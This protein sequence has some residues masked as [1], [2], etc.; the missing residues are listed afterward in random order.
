MNEHEEHHE[1]HHDHEHEHD[2]GAEKS[3][4]IKI[5][6]SIIF[7]IIAFIVKDEIAKK[8]LFLISY[9]IVGFKVLKEAVQNIFK[10]EIFD[11][12]F[13]MSVATI[14]ALIISEFPEAVAAMLLYQIGEFFQGVATEKS[15]K[16][17][18]DLMNIKPDTAT[19]LVDGKEVEM[20]PEKVQIGAEI[21]VKPGE[22]IPLDGVVI[23]GDSF[24]DT[25]ALTG[26]SVPRA[27]KVS[28]EVL[29]G[30]INQNGIL[31]IKVTKEFT[32]ST[33]NK[34]LELTQNA[35]EQKSKSE[36]F[37][38]KFAKVYT[39]TVVLIAVVL[40][41]LPPVI[42]KDEFSKWV[43]RALSFLVV[44][45]PCSLVISIPLSFFGGIGGAAKKGI[46]V[47][48]SNYIEK[49]S[50][51]KIGVFDKTGTLTKGEFKIQEINSVGIEDSELLELT[52][53]TENYSNHPIAKVIKDEYN[54]EI[55]KSKISDIEEISGH[56]IKAIVLG[57]EVLAGN[58]KLMKKEN[59]DFEPKELAETVIYVAVDKKYSGY[60]LISDKIKDDAIEAIKSLK[61]AGIE[62]TV[63]LTGDNEKVA[64]A[65]AKELRIDETYSELLPTDKVQKIKEIIENK[66]KDD[67]VF[68]VGDGINDSPVLAISDIGIAM[69][70]IGQDSAIEAA[71]LVLM[72]D[73]PSK[74]AT[75]IKL[76]KKN[77][78]IVKEN[79]VFSIFVKILVLVLSAL[80]ITNLWLAVFADVGVSVIAILNAL[81]MLK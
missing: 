78:K 31:K 59:I 25:K 55:D 8:V 56:G 58:E 36:N 18:T 54:K 22:K 24:I 20:L 41:V 12:N 9:F 38:T 42:L 14:G 62:K 11:E 61:K 1:H 35:T 3:D 37:I 66:R 44:S 10:G 4:L 39:P 19:V 6:F 17:I 63:M 16:S 79:I 29:S 71:D 34:I 49:M 75:A 27:V 48:G 45:C 30:S 43:Y 65:V 73:E 7:Y 81:R 60:I 47:K 15:K 51:A 26:E 70:G 5:I 57:K 74:I 69:G 33:V 46:L 53:Y 80:G 2:H 77:M 76:S 67:T 28:S 32:E 23:E 13:L 72:T 50:K 52:A 40:A 68:F 21:L 64:I